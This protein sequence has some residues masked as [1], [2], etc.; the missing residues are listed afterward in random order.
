MKKLGIGLAA[1]VLAIGFSAFTHAPAKAPVSYYWFQYDVAGNII[2]PSSPPP[3]LT[4][5]PFTCVGTIRNCASG[6]S[7]Y[8]PDGTKYKPVGSPLVTDKKN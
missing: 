2:E 3:P 5:D 8:A 4:S 7:G 6:F 1:I